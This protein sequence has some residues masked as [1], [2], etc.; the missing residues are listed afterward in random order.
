M[1]TVWVY[2]AG[3]ES[4]RL[5]DDTSNLRLLEVI[6]TD[7]F[8]EIL[9]FTTEGSA[10]QLGRPISLLT[11]ALQAHNWPNY[12]WNF[13]YVNLMIHLL[14][15]CLIFWLLL[16]ITRIMALSERRALLLSL[17]TT[18]VWLLN[19]FQVSTVL[20]IV[21]RMTELSALFSLGALLIYVRSR[22][23]L[24]QGLLTPRAFWIWISLGIGLG[25]ILATLSKENGVLLVLYVLVLEATVLRSLPKPRY[26]QAWCG[27]F[28]YL[29]LSLLAAYFLL[30][31]DNL[32]KGYEIRHFSL[33][34]R[35]LTETRILSDYLF[36]ILIPQPHSYGLFHD[37]YVVSRHLL[38]P[39]TTVFA[40]GFVTLMLFAA[41]LWRIKYPVF[42]FAVLWFL[43]SH[44]LES[45]FIGLMLYFEHRNYLAM[46][47]VL[48]AVIYGVL[49][50]F[51]RIEN[52]F[53]HKVAILFSA[54]YLLLFSIVTV[55]EVD[56]WSKPLMQ[57]TVRTE[58][59]PQSR[60]ALSHAASVFVSVGD[61]QKALKYYRYMVETFSEDSGPYAL[62]LAASC[63]NSNIPLP[64]IQPVIHRFRTSKGD[65]ATINGLI[66]VIEQKASGLCAHVS[67]ETL[68]TLFE[69]LAENKVL[70]NFYRDD[71]YYL[72]AK[73]YANEKRYGDAISMADKSL[74]LAPNLQLQ[75]QRL[76]WLQL[77]GRDREALD[78]IV[79][80]RADLNLFSRYLYLEDLNKGEKLIQERL[81]ISSN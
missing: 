72:Y 4:D 70:E 28:L 7:N 64:E 10:G 31:F 81:E 46:L 22:Q 17:F 39:M 21:Q 18:S 47:G 68:D 63:Y 19:P 23:Q 55:L 40:V 32:L 56:L 20:Y 15:G 6:N 79:K 38:S 51:D 9:R 35:L 43:A 66:F 29:P 48:F 54:L 65:N 58:Q 8:T 62:W 27:V 49:W 60:N 24:A 75:L 16:Y 53:L 67:S 77:A 71:I 14:N 44:V 52:T 73:F 42:A 25:G 57:A 11:F 33:G 50:M 45:S 30:T 2:W 5:L 41:L 13:K 80:M 36:R 26:W 74:F 34:E 37:D 3:L 12:L 69:A 1:C 78:D 76:S 59:H 61:D